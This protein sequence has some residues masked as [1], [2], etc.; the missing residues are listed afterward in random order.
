MQLEINE[1]IGK[2]LYLCIQFSISV[3]IVVSE[4]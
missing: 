2:A 3:F 1:C 4:D